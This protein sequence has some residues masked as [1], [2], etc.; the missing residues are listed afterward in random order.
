VTLGV[1]IWTRNVF[2]AVIAGGIT[3]YSMLNISF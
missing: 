1:G 3:L 2:V